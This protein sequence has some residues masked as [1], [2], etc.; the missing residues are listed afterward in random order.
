MAETTDPAD[1]DIFERLRYQKASLS[2]IKGCLKT[3]MRMMKT[4]YGKPVI[5]LIDEYDVPLAKASERNNAQNQYYMQMLDLIKGML[6]VSLKTNE[7]LKEIAAICGIEKNLT[8]HCARHTAA[9]R[10]LNHRP[11]IP[12]ETIRQVFGWTNESIVRHYAKIFNSTVFED[13]E[14]AFGPGDVTKPTNEQIYIPD[15]LKD[16][17]DILDSI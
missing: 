13:I 5:L 17:Q 15:D 10:Y 4:V 8:F 11:S 2:D 6:S 16:F 12:L 9:C 7:Y 14:K 3:I 1:R